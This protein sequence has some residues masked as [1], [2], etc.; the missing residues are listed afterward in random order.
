MTGAAH[1]GWRKDPY[2][3]HELRYWD[4]LAWTAQVNDFGIPGDDPVFPVVADD[5]RRYLAP[6]RPRRRLPGLDRAAAW[7]VCG[8]VGVI[9]LAGLSATQR[10]PV[11]SAPPVE[12]VE[13]AA[14]DVPPATDPPPG[15]PQ[16]ALAALDRLPVRTSGS[17]SRPS[18][19]ARFSWVDG[20]RD[21]CDVRQDVLRRDLT[22]VHL[23][24][25]G[26]AVRSGVLRDPWTGAMIDYF[27]HRSGRRDPV[28][29]VQVV[30]P[31]AAWRTGGAELGRGGWQA[32]VNDPLNLSAVSTT[33]ERARGHQDAAAWL[34]P[35]RTSRCAYVARQ[36]AVKAGH[37]LWV[38]KAERAVMRSVLAGCPAEPLPAG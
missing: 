12:V 8:F 28:R 7:A 34:P 10:I 3:R 33:A 18:R 9:A 6:S 32:L 5:P 21:G 26:C 14:A 35:D 15:H 27:A 20:D 30:A 29:V 37:G 19:P 25:G 22:R 2:R 4:G 36:I 38:T 23:F 1:E 11:A 17:A 13:A 16:T 24:E 31:D